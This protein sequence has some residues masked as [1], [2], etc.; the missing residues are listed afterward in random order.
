MPAMAA[1]TR[2]GARGTCPVA[3]ASGH[4]G[5]RH[6]RALRAG[7]RQ[8]LPAVTCSWELAANQEAE[9]AMRRGC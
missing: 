8:R 1:R 3:D 2:A 4:G 5:I 6:L 9:I 7:G